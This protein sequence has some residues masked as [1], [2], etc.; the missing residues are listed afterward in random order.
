MKK[1]QKFKRKTVEVKKLRVKKKLKNIQ[2][3]KKG[4]L[5]D[6]LIKITREKI[7]R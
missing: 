7:E 6:K 3:C 1:L 4:Q 5:E 2:K